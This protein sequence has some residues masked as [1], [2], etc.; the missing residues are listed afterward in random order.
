MPA[1]REAMFSSRFFLMCGF[2]FTVFLSVFTLLPTTPFRILALGGSTLSAGLFLGFLTY[3]SALSAPITGALADR[4][5]KR[6]MLVTCGLALAGFFTAYGL[7]QG[8][9]V[10]LGWRWC[11]GSSG[12]ASGR[13][14]RL[15]DRPHPRSRGARREWATGASPAS[16]P[17]RSLP[18]S[19]SGSTST[20]GVCC[21]A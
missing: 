19:A 16:R 1:A 17:W 21:A 13:L 6:R 5:G 12:R 20:A 4:I 10:L 2:S 11:T 15:H 7:A 8:Y 14:G 3:A 18:R 9:R